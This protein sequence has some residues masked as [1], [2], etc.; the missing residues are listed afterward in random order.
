MPAGLGHGLALAAAA[1]A[2]C[3]RPATTSGGPRRR[4]AGRDLDVGHAELGAV[5]RHVGVVP[6]QP[7]E[8]GAVGREA[9]IG[10]EVGT[11]DDDRRLELA[12][13]V[14]HHD[15][16]DHVTV[17]RVTLAHDGEPPAGR[18]DVAV[19]PPIAPGHGGLG[20]DR[21]GH[22]P[23]GE[24]VQ[25]LVGPVGEPQRPA[26]HP[27]RSPAVF[28]HGGAGVEPGGQQ[29]HGGSVA[30]ALDD[31]R[32]PALLGSH[33][34][35][36]DRVA[37]DGD[38]AEPG[39]SSHHELRR[40]GGRPRAVRATST[41]GCQTGPH[42]CTGHHA[43]LGQRRRRGPQGR[44]R[45]VRQQRV[46]RPLPAHRRR[47]ADR[48]RQRARAAARAVPAARTSAGSSRPTATGT[49]SRPCP[50]SARPATRSP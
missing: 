44:R 21:H 34:R 26:V 41:P 32:P 7:A 38:A 9:G 47:R 6:L 22:R 46:R 4:S 43:A 49:T 37:V 36:G 10:H 40:D 29:I 8:A 24:P 19:G 5:P 42:D 13:S 27:P 14:E 15:L 3:G 48:R 50:R 45:P 1:S 39:G 11:G 25:P 31:L 12:R 23:A 33:L 18:V 17:G 28:V 16:V 2:R 20:G 35:P 30:D